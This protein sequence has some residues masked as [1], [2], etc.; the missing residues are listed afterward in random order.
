MCQPRDKEEFNHNK[1]LLVQMV[2]LKLFIEME[3]NKLLFM[4][5]LED[6]EVIY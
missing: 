4:Y 2:Q 3:I 1:L 5:P 6:K